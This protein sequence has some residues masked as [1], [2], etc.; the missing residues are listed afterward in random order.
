MSRNRTL[1][2][3]P[4]R[5]R[6]TVLAIRTNSQVFTSRANENCITIPILCSVSFCAG[7]ATAHCFLREKL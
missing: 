5:L 6:S 4:H 1:R 7:H 2:Y 3:K